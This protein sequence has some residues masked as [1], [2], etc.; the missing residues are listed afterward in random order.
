MPVGTWA[1]LGLSV[2]ISCL[3]CGRIVS[4]NAFFLIRH[5]QINVEVTISQLNGKQL[6]K[7]EQCKHREITV[8]ITKNHPRTYPSE[9]AIEM[10]D[11]R[12]G[13]DQKSTKI[14]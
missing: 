8:G 13:L 11:K 2:S 5:P 12:K 4:E 14:A 6:F 7:C 9:E 10:Y 1:D 3:L